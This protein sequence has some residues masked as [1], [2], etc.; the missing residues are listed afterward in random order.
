MNVRHLLICICLT[1][2]CEDDEPPS[3]FDVA[4]SIVSEFGNSI[5]GLTNSDKFQL[6]VIDKNHPNTI[7]KGDVIWSSSDEEVLKVSSSGQVT[8]VDYGSAIVTMTALDQM[9]ELSIDI[10]PFSGTHHTKVL[11]I[12]WDFMKKWEIPGASLGIVK[13]ERLLIKTALGYAIA[14]D[15]IPVSTD[16]QFRIASVSKSITAVGI[17]KL[18]EQGK[19]SLDDQVFGIDGILSQY[20][21]LIEPDY[22]LI[23]IRH[24]LH[25]S[26]GWDSTL[27]GDPMFR[28]LEIANFL[29][30]N[31][32]VTPNQ[33]IQFMTEF[34]SLDFPVGSKFSYSNVGYLILGRIIETISGMLYED[35]VRSEILLPVE[36]TNTVLAKNL[37]EDRY[38]NEV[39]YYHNGSLTTLP[40]VYGTGQLL[41]VP[42]GGILLEAMDAHGGWV[43]TAD[44]LLRFLTAVDGFHERTEILTTSSLITMHTASPHFSQ[45]GMGWE[46]IGGNWFHTGSLPGSSSLIYRGRDGVSYAVLFNSWPILEQTKYNPE[47]RSMMNGLVSSID[48]WPTQD[49]F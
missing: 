10:V 36:A 21:I 22:E 37:F 30:V 25:H 2:S 12:L 41:P 13:D 1:L 4:L 8:P 24:L 26:A 35:F 49:L 19:L 28:T 7:W 40:S 9:A 20:D 39:K 43:S 18:I 17:F 45:Y 42:Y 11:S 27:G 31:N 38:Q 14:E 23:T 33:I 16:S 34:Y 29:N 44:D 32:P 5:F 46:Q 47:M 48:Q 15:G 3:R 6:N